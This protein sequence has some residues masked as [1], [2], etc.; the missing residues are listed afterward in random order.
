[1]LDKNPDN[2]NISEQQRL[3]LLRWDG[4]GGASRDGPQ[5]AAISN[6]V[7]AELPCNDKCP[8][9]STSHSHHR[10]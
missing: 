2:S 6:E 8:V 10:A 3:A 4:E 9:D 1:M 7:E 5:V